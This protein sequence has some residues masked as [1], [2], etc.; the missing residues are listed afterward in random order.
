MVM[1]N[2][3]LGYQEGI[4]PESLA[5]ENAYS[6]VKNVSLFLVTSLELASVSRHQL[7]SLPA[8]S[9]PEGGRRSG[10]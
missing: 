7:P 4:A 1:R 2:T 5:L 10:L 8:R 3:G 6:I 9:R